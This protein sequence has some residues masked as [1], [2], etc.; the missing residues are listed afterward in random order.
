MTFGD[1]ITLLGFNLQD[2][3]EKPIEQTAGT[4]LPNFKLNPV[5][6]AHLT[7]FWQAETQP[8]ADYTVFIHL[9]DAAGQLIAQFDGPPAT[10]AY[11]TSLWDPGEI[12]ID[13][14]LLTNIPLSFAS[15]QVGLYHSHLGERL[16]I[17]STGD[18]VLTLATF[19]SGVTS[20]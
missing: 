10:G 7:L 4:S 17:S 9:T 18:N 14:R 6:T 11:P 8:T 16:L 20:P 13:E 19:H 3:N 12:I 15:L 2:E 5:Q 1:R